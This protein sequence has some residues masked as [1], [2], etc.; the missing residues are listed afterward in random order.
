MLKAKWLL[1]LAERAWQCILQIP[2]LLPMMEQP[3]PLLRSITCWTISRYAEWVVTD[4]Q[5]FLD[6]VIN[7]LLKCILDKNKVV[8]EA[9]CSALA[10]FE[11]RVRA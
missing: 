1:R 8:Q 3:R 9:A 6:G 2:F 4:G 11:E 7:S 5:Q 10:T